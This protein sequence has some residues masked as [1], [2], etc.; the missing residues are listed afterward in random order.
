MASPNPAATPHPHTRA[1]YPS[2]PLPDHV[3]SAPAYGPFGAIVISPHAT[4]RL[5]PPRLFLLCSF[6]A[7]PPLP[8]SQK[9]SRPSLG[10]GG[11][12]ELNRTTEG[13][14]NLPQV[15]APA[16]E[17]P[18]WSVRAG[19]DAVRPALAR[20][21]AIPA[22]PLAATSPVAGCRRSPEGRHAR[23]ARRD[24]TRRRRTALPRVTDTTPAAGWHRHVPPSVSGARPAAAGTTRAR[25]WPVR[26]ALSHAE[27]HLW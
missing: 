16:F 11:E 3:P 8:A 25:R 15:E 4:P 17:A 26:A 9:K 6:H 22:A 21:R 23:A 1:T 2:Q 10:P 27:H 13:F 24:R 18:A 7:S 20:A 19:G 14:R 12:V 5:G